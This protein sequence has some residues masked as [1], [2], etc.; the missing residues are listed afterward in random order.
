MTLLIKD[1]ADHFA[2]SPSITNEFGS[3]IFDGVIPQEYTNDQGVKANAY[4]CI[5]INEV[6]ATPDYYLG[7]E[8]GS[9][10]SNVQVDVYTTGVGGAARCHELAELVRRRL[11]G[12]RGVLG[13]GCF[14]NMAEL[15]RNSPFAI[16]PV[17]ASGL[18]KRRRS[19]EFRIRHTA[20]VPTFA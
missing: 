10:E 19:M 16:P 13:T 7:G 4:P 6:S 14:C 18:H 15:T 1:V 2:G 17:N 8:V 20:D 9:H 12:Y 5:V 3:R 11:S